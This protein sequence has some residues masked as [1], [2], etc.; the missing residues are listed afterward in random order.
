MAP[1][2]GPCNLPK[3]K[4]EA[5]DLIGSEGIEAVAIYLIETY[6]SSFSPKN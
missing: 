1:R 3:F 4:T 6:S 5:T 2:S